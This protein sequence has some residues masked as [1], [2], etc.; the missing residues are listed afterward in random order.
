MTHTARV[1]QISKI[2]F[3]SHV[4]LIAASCLSAFCIAENN[5][6]QNPEK[7]LSEHRSVEFRFDGATATKQFFPVAVTDEF[8][9]EFG[10][11]YDLGTTPAKDKAYY[12][13]VAVP[14]GNYRIT[15]EL[16]N[17]RKASATTLKAESRRLYL[18]NEKASEGKFISRSFVVN[19]RN[20]NLKVPENLAPG[21][22]KV[23]LKSREKD[24]L[25][26]DNKLTLE[27]NG[28][29]PQLHSLRIEPVNVPTI[30]LVGDST[31]TDQAYE[32][33]ASWGQMLPYFFNDQIAIA[34]H[35]ESGET[36]KSFISEGRLA[37]VLDQL[38]PSDYLFIQ[39]GHNDQKKQW[40]QTYVE[41]NTTYKD[42][43][44]AFIDEAKLRD[45]M[46]VLVTSMQRRKFDSNGKIINTHGDY[47]K[48]V[49]ELAAAEQVP[50]IDL[51]AMSIDLY[52]ALGPS[53]A[54]LLFNDGGKDA[55]HHNNYGAY[56]LAKCVV[57]GMRK[58]NLPLVANLK[59]DLPLFDPTKPDAP[60]NFS[61]SASPQVSSVRPD[62]N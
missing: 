4:S 11:G 13:S 56:E 43:L 61:L 10:F 47:P 5:I 20:A 7:I 62:G 38:K 58:S 50:L 55:T 3:A 2:M 32:P 49:R 33:A 36:L 26:W 40:P 51:E 30:F 31:V 17:K 34:N 53:K 54:P 19:V 59:K 6:R 60:E 57:E 25:H 23:A 48:A 16:G 21:S 22:L 1:K 41:A 37:K 12:F 29:A 15:V 28:D 45:A 42:Y 9:P 44:K 46:P 18:N 24:A 8:K 14:E 35:A 39:F 52:E 27:I